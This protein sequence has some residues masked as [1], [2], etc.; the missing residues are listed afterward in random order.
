MLSPAATLATPNLSKFLGNIPCHSQEAA[1]PPL[2]IWAGSSPPSNSILRPSLSSL[3]CRYCPGRLSVFT[4]CHDHAAGPTPHPGHRQARNGRPRVEET[5]G[6]R[7]TGRAQLISGKAGVERRPLPRG[8]VKCS[9][10]HLQASVPSQSTQL[11][12]TL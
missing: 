6:L 12:V 10:P 11:T 2:P 1:S 4:S 9:T 5:V 7:G 3:T 8:T